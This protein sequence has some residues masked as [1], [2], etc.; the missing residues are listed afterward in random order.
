MRRGATA[1]ALSAAGAAGADVAAACLGL[2]GADWPEDFELLRGELPA[3]ARPALAPLILN[4]A[5]APIRA[6]STDGVGG[7][8]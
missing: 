1:G 6:G 8:W 5:I 4:D 3:A 2:A 7:R